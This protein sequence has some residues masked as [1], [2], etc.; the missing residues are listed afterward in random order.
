MARRLLVRQLI[1]GS[2]PVAHPAEKRMEECDGNCGMTGDSCN[3]LHLTECMDDGCDR[4]NDLLEYYEACDFCGQWGHKDI[5]PC[6][7]PEAQ[8]V[9]NQ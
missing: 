2:I 5:Q 8:R 3:I 7:C 1:A 6:S 4:C 9:Y